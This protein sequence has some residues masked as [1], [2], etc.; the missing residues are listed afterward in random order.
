MSARKKSG[1]AY[2]RFQALPPVGP[3]V[4]AARMPP[5][6]DLEELA[7]EAQRGR[8][9]MRELEIDC[10]EHDEPSQDLQ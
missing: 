2:G 3:I 6:V 10:P 5:P 9:L 7:R 8:E 4:R 1:R